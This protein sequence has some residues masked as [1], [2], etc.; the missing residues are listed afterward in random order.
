[1]AANRNFLHYSHVFLVFGAFKAISSKYLS[2]LYVY[3]FLKLLIQQKCWHQQ[4]NCSRQQIFLSCIFTFQAI[5]SIFFCWFSKVFGR[6]L[7]K[8]AVLI[9]EF[10][11]FPKAFS[12][13]LILNPSTQ[14]IQTILDLA[15]VWGG[16]GAHRPGKND[17]VWN[18]LTS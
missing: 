11:A 3:W 9:S 10:T 12:L 1:M 17:N 4:K 15:Q 18:A 13:V 8:S 6:K 2:W 14:L 5:L 16:G 7:L